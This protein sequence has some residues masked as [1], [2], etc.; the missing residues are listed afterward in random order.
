MF[1]TNDWE[2]YSSYFG[3]GVG[4]AGNWATA[5]SLTFMVGLGTLTEPVSVSFSLLVCYKE[6]TLRLGLVEVDSSAILDLFGS[7]QFT[8]CPQAIPFF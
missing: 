3:E 1:H 8:L 4:I 5:H 6:H 7:N 2:E